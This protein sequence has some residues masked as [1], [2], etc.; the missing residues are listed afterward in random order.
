[1]LISADSH[2]VEPPDLWSRVDAEF[3]DRAPQLVSTD[4]GDA[5][6]FAGGRVAPYASFATAGEAQ[7]TGATRQATLRPALFDPLERLAEAEADGVGVEVL[8]PSFAMHLYENFDPGLQAA[9]M[10]AYND[11][12]AE[13]C[14]A[15][16]TRLFPV[17]M[18]PTDPDGALAEMRRI[19]GKPYKGVLINAHPRVDRD[20]GTMLYEDLWAILAESG[21]P[22]CMHLY[23]GD[24]RPADEHFLATYTVDPNLIQ[25]TLALMIFAG[26]LE[27]YPS[28]QVVSVESDIG[29]VAQM[30]RRMDHAWE[31]KGLRFNKALTSGVI[32]SDMFKRQ[33]TCTFTDDRPGILCLPETGADIFMWGSDYPHNDSSWPHSRQVIT[34]TL[35]GLT[36]ADQQ[37]L[38]HDNAAR[39][40]G[41]TE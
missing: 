33:V 14:A 25:H 12:I 19:Q 4:T 35:T 6:A 39:V 24:S 38:V 29:W 11:W 23:A 36:E 30:L 7:A 22:A 27:R 13:F 20:Y 8:F 3:R 34:D 28:L 2:V 18:L 17:A 41:I 40:F 37:K 15:A 32:P 9:C 5:I 1:M 16:P 10:R 31:R 26:V 21:L